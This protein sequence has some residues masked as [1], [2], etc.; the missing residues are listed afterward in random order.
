MSSST[1]GHQAQV[2]HSSFVRPA[3]GSGCC[4]IG[5][6]ISGSSSSKCAG[7]VYVLC[8]AKRGVIRHCS[9]AEA[10]GRGDTLGMRG[11]TLL[12]LV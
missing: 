5:S 11:D 6:K 2:G 4:N 3:A 9:A 8:T 1:A 12:H 10:G 7:L